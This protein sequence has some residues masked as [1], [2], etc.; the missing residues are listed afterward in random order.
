M[1][2]NKEEDFI[3]GSKEWNDVLNTDL[4]KVKIT[5]EM[6]ERSQKAS[7]GVRSSVRISTGIVW[8]DDE[9]EE[10]RNKILNPSFLP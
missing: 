3:P 9:Y 6:V 8:A 7:R 2:N 5:K 4:P 1:N 10:Y